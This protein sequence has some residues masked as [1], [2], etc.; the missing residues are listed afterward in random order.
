V[1][2]L[3]DWAVT[4]AKCEPG[5]KVLGTEVCHSGCLILSHGKFPHLVWDPND[6]NTIH[7]NMLVDE[8]FHKKKIKHGLLDNI[9]VAREGKK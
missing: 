1:T 5:T 9:Y 3:E 8:V 6:H 4:V 7:E 2:Q